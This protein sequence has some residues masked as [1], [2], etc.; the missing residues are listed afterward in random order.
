MLEHP[1]ASVPS[2]F[3]QGRRCCSWFR[4]RTS[5]FQTH[6]PGF[7]V[8]CSKRDAEA[9]ACLLVR[10]QKLIQWFSC[11]CGY[12][13]IKGAFPGT[14]ILRIWGFFPPKSSLFPL[15]AVRF[16]PQSPQGCCGHWDGRI[17]RI[18]SF[19]PVAAGGKKK[20]TGK[21]KALG[22]APATLCHTCPVLPRSFPG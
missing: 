15:G 13:S 11:C 10:P 8:F 17:P 16:K 3:A 7:Q 1:L 2:S 6:F 14:E 5:I 22:A 20:E 21:Q 19:P 4:H 12:I 18:S 9:A